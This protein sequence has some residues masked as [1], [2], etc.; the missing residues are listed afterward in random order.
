MHFP[1]NPSEMA[2]VHFG[3][4]R[5]Y[6]RLAAAALRSPIGASTRKSIE[7]ETIEALPAAA[8]AAEEIAPAD[9]G[10]IAAASHTLR[11]IFDRARGS[12]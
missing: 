5:A 1:K 9:E 12:S 4:V 7:D 6:W 11:R 2:L 10:T 8:L 3:M